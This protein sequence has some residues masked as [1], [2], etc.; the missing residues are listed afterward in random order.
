MKNPINWVKM[1]FNKKNEYD[2]F[3]EK[4][5][6]S[7]NMFYNL[8]DKANKN[9]KFIAD[10]VDKL[11]KITLKFQTNDYTIEFQKNTGIYR[12]YI[13]TNM[14]IT[15]FWITSYINRLFDVKSQIDNNNQILF[16]KDYDKPNY[17]RLSRLFDDVNEK[18]DYETWIKNN[19]IPDIE[20]IKSDTVNIIQKIKI[21]IE[22]I[23]FISS[24]VLNKDS[25]GEFNEYFKN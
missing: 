14:D 5:D 18:I 25:L 24:K 2:K 17:F 3:L 15:F 19:I 22:M 23:K 20:D 16:V 10:T 1:I 21:I 6:F 12:V 4:G 9:I 8:L 7:D 11:K 13:F